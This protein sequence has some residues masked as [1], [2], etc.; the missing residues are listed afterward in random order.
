M[1][2][3]GR[4]IGGISIL[5]AASIALSISIYIFIYAGA[6]IYLRIGGVV[7][8]IVA[9]FYVIGGLFLIKDKSW[10]CTMTLVVGTFHV[11]GTFIDIGWALAFGPMDVSPLVL[12]MFYL[13]PALA[14]IG[15]F[16]GYKG[17]SEW[18]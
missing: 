16:L 4:I 8:M 7:T 3:R 9:V 13:E 5:A 12:T 1:T 15:A 14:I 6:T 2:R 11:I 17:G 10:A 18:R